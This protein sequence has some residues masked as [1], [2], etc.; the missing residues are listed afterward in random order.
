LF[1]DMLQFE[2]EI[3]EAP[4]LQ[5]TTQQPVMPVAQVPTTPME[6]QTNILGQFLQ[7]TQQRPQGLL[8]GRRV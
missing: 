1:K 2:T 5:I 6:A 3:T 7:P 4:R 8:T